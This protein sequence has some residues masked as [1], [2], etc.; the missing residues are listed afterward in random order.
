MDIFWNDKYQRAS[1]YLQLEVFVSATQHDYIMLEHVVISTHTVWFTIKNFLSLLEQ[2]MHLGTPPYPCA[3][4]H[5]RKLP[6]KQ[7][8][9]VHNY[10][11]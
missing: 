7:L 4:R 10:K 2:Q 1:C 3:M 8:H 9:S 6:T 11:L 5:Q